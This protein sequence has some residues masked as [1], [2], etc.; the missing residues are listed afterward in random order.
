MRYNQNTITAQEDFYRQEIAA[1][2]AQGFI[3]YECGQEMDIAGIYIK[4]SAGVDVDTLES[5]AWTVAKSFAKMF[6]DNDGFVAFA[7]YNGTT[8]EFLCKLENDE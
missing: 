2:R 1:G 6:S 3:V 4:N 8:N 7:K 5:Y